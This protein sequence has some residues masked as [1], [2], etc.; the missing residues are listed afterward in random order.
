MCK[1]FSSARSL[2]NAL[3]VYQYVGIPCCGVDVL[4]GMGKC[5]LGSVSGLLAP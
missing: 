5:L 3:A 2:C 1:V 4:K